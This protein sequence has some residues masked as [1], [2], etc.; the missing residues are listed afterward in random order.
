M[1]AAARF[2]GVGDGMARRRRESRGWARSGRCPEVGDDR[3]RAADGWVPTG[4]ERG[5]EREARARVT[6]VRAVRLQSDGGE[7][8]GAAR[9]AGWASE[10]AARGAKRAKEAGPREEIG[11]RA[12]GGIKKGF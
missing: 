4:S 7:R 11:P 9:G 5:R 6:R 8:E 10:Q 1:V 12:K 3:E 2:Q